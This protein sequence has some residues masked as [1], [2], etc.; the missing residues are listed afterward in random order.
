[1][2][3]LFKKKG[4]NFMKNHRIAAGGIVIKNERIL[5]VRYKND[6]YGSFLATPGG[7]LEE[8]ENIEKAIKREILEETGIAVVP[9]S[10]LMIED[11]D[12][13]KFKM[14][15]IWMS[16]KYIKGEI[17]ETQAAKT[18]GICEVGWYSKQDIL[19]EVVF[20]S[21]IKDKEWDLMMK[22]KNEIVIP[23]SRKASF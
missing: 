8:N 11:L 20:P 3:Y 10:V 6:E 4:N 16:C 18:E 1:M 14:C 23:L 5:L 2:P 12:C 7:A 17:V 15:K 19:H 21:I 22:L 9:I 13:S